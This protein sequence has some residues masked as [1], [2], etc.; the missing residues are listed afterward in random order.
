MS[1]K[2][3]DRAVT[4]I[5]WGAGLLIIGVLTLFLGYILIKGLPVLSLA[6]IFGQSSDI[7]AGGGVGA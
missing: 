4:A 6:F 5:L 3:W 2:Q 7:T 1:A